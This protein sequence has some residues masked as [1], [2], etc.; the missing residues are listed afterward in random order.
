MSRDL[1]KCTA[2][3][4]SVRKGQ[5][6][7]M[8]IVKRTALFRSTQIQSRTRRL[9]HPMHMPTP[10]QCTLSLKNYH[11]QTFWVMAMQ[12]LSTKV[13]PHRVASSRYRPWFRGSNMLDCWE[14]ECGSA[15]KGSTLLPLSDFIQALSHIIGIIWYFATLAISHTWFHQFSANFS[16]NVS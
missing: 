6:K 5:S 11:P 7:R 9:P 14:G 13:D 3:Q 12:G 16:P 8:K 15:I 2:S 4:R 1:C 10:T